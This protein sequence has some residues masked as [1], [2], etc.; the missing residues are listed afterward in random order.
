MYNNNSDN[1]I[2]TYK[3]KHIDIYTLDIY[4]IYILYDN[5]YHRFMD[6]L[7]LINYYFF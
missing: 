7:L 3:H 5:L 2:W 4:V 6:I 1:L